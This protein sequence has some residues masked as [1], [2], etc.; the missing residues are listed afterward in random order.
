MSTTVEK[1]ILER[2]QKAEKEVIKTF[3]K[4]DMLSLLIAG[5]IL[6]KDKEGDIIC[7]NPGMKST[8]LTEV[9]VESDELDTFT[10]EKLIAKESDILCSVAEE[11]E[12]SLTCALSGIV[13]SSTQRLEV[14]KT[15][16]P[17]NEEFDDYNPS[18]VISFIQG[19]ANTQFQ[20]PGENLLVRL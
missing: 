20:S 12:H 16:R 13:A 5:H 1:E 4:L 15:D 7:L 18:F 2:L 9:S 14:G 3:E 17:K 10:V 19:C 6:R 11:N 8:L